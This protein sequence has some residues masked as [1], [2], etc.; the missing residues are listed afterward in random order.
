MDSRRPKLSVYER[1]LA[2]FVRKPS[3][4]LLSSFGPSQN[5]IVSSWDQIQ[6]QIL[7][8]RHLTLE[9][10]Q[11]LRT[12]VTIDDE[13]GEEAVSGQAAASSRQLALYE[14]PICE[15]NESYSIGIALTLN[16]TS[17]P[18]ADVDL[19][20][21][22]A[23]LILG[24]IHFDFGKN[25]DFLQHATSLDSITDA[26]VHHFDASLRYVAKADMWNKGGRDY[27][28]E[29]IWHF[30]SRGKKIELCLP[31]FP[32][33]S[34]N[35]GKV[36]GTSPDRG[37][38][39]AL[40][41]L[42]SFIE[43][44]ERL[45]EP[46]AKLWIISDG[47]VFSD[48][49]GVDDSAV[50]EYGAQLIAMSNSIALQR[51]GVDRIG[52]KSLVD[53]F[54]VA[55]LEGA[56]LGPS[57]DA[58]MPSVQHFLGTKLT[59]EAETCRRILQEAFQLDHGELRKRLD[60]QDTGIVAL[61]RGFS[62]FMLEDLALNPYTRGRSQSQRRKLS[63]K[64]AFEMIQRN[65]AYSNLVEV[66]FPH[67]VRLSIHAH[68]NIGPKFG[69]QMLGSGV[70]STNVLSPDGGLVKFCDELH[71]PTPWHNCIV[72]IEGHPKL[73]ITKSSIVLSALATGSFTGGWT[74]TQATG[75]HFYLRPSTSLPAAPRAQALASAPLLMEK[76]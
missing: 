38:F 54:A 53:L 30:V 57:L 68:N 69:I 37:E 35:Q 16:P 59:E 34:S 1:F 24:G 36:Q 74:G 4:E 23:S 71:V 70:R 2:G 55:K 67:H 58:K 32:C 63:S 29:R 43:G 50:D 76:A 62:K 31:A 10:G 39:I 18:A 72:E 73:Y 56:N 49:I 64:V 12:V 21:F 65:Q 5:T 48:C 61:Y 26:I 20:V 17:T 60:S 46:G 52:F 51:G 13:A 14:H 3:G 22:F 45:Y 28:R 8:Y 15:A 7:K 11:P 9:P 27:F 6:M 42:H 33:K 41:N 25:E 40:S 44:I 47:H 66:M 75:A 19:D